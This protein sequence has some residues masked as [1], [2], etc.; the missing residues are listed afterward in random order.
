MARPLE[1]AK[2]GTHPQEVFILDR[3]VLPETA[4]CQ[5]MESLENEGKSLPFD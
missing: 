3:E 2:E 1:E 5:L 4:F